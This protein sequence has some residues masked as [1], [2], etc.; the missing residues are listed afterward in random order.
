VYFHVRRGEQGRWT[1]VH[2]VGEVDLATAPRYRSELVAAAADADALA[3]DL[4]SCD[5]IDSVGLGVT[6]GAA[7]RVR[8][9]DGRFAVV[10]GARVRR[11]FETSRIDE[12]VDVV[13]SLDELGE[14]DEPVPA[15]PVDAEAARP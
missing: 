6:V 9:R 3:V 13:V 12:I 4:T 11:T 7:R 8:A 14:P 1:V 2:V 10:A 5:L 15:R